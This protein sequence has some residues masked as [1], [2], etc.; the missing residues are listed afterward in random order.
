[1]I[2]R[3][4]LIADLIMS[5]KYKNIA[6]I[7]VS[8]GATT[9]AIETLLT[10]NGYSLDSYKG[11][12]S[13][14]DKYYAITETI[15]NRLSTWHPWSLL[16]MTSDKAVQCMRGLEL[17]FIDGSHDENQMCK[18]IMQY[19][20]A[21][22]NGG[23]LVGH[24]FLNPLMPKVTSYLEAIMGKEINIV[25]D[26]RNENGKPNYLWWTYKVEEGIYAKIRPNQI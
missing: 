9:L 26:K 5:N 22:V 2:S 13:F 18:D 7:G 1:V 16:E 24:D 15:K 8:K 12:D 23:C 17:V 21:L 11:I 20:D 14:I 10:R 3:S 19:G 25:Q 4:S 6:E